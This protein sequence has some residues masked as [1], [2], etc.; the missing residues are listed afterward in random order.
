MGVQDALNNFD[1]ALDFVYLAGDVFNNNWA[2]GAQVLTN[3]LVDPDAM[4]D[5]F[6]LTN[7]VGGTVNYKYIMNTFA[8]G[9]AYALTAPHSGNGC[10]KHFPTQC[11]SHFRNGEE[12]RHLRL[13]IRGEARMR[14]RFDI[15]FAKLFYTSA[16]GWNHHIP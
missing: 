14:Q 1:P 9:Q 10:P 13:H 8:N 16:P 7:T 15:A 2:V 5:T 4:C 12:D 3:S 6:T 11:W